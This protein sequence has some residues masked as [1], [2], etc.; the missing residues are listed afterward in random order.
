MLLPLSHF[1]GLLVYFVYGIHNSKENTPS[2]GYGQIVTFS[3]DASLPE[4]PIQGLYEEIREQQPD[5]K[6]ESFVS[7]ASQE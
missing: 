4:N 3:G 7:P 2:Q 1:K 5:R 6:D